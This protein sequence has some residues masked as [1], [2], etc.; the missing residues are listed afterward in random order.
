[1][2]LNCDTFSLPLR[3]IRSLCGIY[4][5]FFFFDVQFPCSSSHFLPSPVMPKVPFSSSLLRRCCV[6]LFFP[7]PF[8][9]TRCVRH[10]SSSPLHV[11]T[12][13]QLAFPFPIPANGWK[14]TSPLFPGGQATA[15]FFSLRPLLSPPFLPHGGGGLASPTLPPWPRR[16]PRRQNHGF[17]WQLNAELILLLEI[18]VFSKSKEK[19]PFHY[20]TFSPQS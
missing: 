14:T 7:P 17:L 6:F 2:A 16:V 12:P 15:W 20:F 9:S 5:F 10:F 11:R 4:S 13:M 3:K 1:L 18:W 8:H 19:L